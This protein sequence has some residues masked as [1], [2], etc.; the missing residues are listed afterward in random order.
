LGELVIDGKS[1]KME[2]WDIWH[3][4]IA[5]FYWLILQPSGGLL[6]TWQLTFISIK[7]GNIFKGWVAISL[8]RSTLFSELLSVKGSWWPLVLEV[9]NACA[10]Q[11]FSKGE[12]KFYFP[13]HRIQKIYSFWFYDFSTSLQLISQ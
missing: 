11:K 13:S 3:K 1:L 2:L 9:D 5:G 6:W 10:L 4:G 8:Y 12:I 7:A